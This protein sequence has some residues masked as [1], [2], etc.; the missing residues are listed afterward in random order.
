M[1]DL[2]SGR[3]R[4]P[5]IKLKLK[6]QLSKSHE[7][8]FQE[9]W[10]MVMDAF[11]AWLRDYERSEL[12]ERKGKERKGK[13]RKG[14]ERKGKERKGKERKGTELMRLNFFAIIN[15]ALAPAKA[16]AIYFREILLQ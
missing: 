3:C 5:F 2:K 7:S 6:A 13:E 10:H 1:V 12:V 4:A 15:D 9:V 11:Q 8:R 14:K 16:E